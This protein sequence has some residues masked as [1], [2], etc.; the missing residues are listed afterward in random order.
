MIIDLEKIKNLQTIEAKHCISMFIKTHRT[1]H[2]EEDKIRWKNAISNAAEILIDQG[3][4]PDDIRKVLRPAKQLL[5]NSDFW[6][7]LSDGLCMFLSD[8]HSAYFSLPI[9]FENKVLVDHHYIT[10]PLIEYL[11][12]RQRYFIFDFSLGHARFFEANKDSITPV[13]IEDLIVDDVDK[14]KEGISV[15]TSLEKSGKHMLHGK[16]DTDYD[17]VLEERHIKNLADGLKA[18]FSKERVPL[19]LSGPEASIAMF[20]KYS[21]YKYIVDA[22]LKGNNAHM[23]AIQIHDNT[24]PILMQFVKPAEIISKKLDDSSLI[25]SDLSSIE[26]LMKT[27]NISQLLFKRNILKLESEEILKVEKMIRE[28]LNIGAKI[29]FEINDE[30]KEQADLHNSLLAKK[31]YA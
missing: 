10:G 30:S 3:A 28:A 11:S 4:E 9:A 13:M 6:L 21:D 16:G 29:E 24:W 27:K 7:N 12:N 8:N 23:D 19:V 14:Q 5:D 25:E 20:K 22:Y 15:A 1:G 26:Y 18:I 17:E 2:V 31:Y